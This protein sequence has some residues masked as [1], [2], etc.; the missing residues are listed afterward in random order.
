MQKSQTAPKATPQEFADDLL[1]GADAIAKFLFGPAGSRRKVYH[2][3]SY[4]R[5]PVFR[6]GSRLCAR[7]SVLLNW[8]GE[9]ENRAIYGANCKEP[10]NIESSDTLRAGARPRE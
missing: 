10:S 6:L 1:C 8:I 7:P 2:L 4:S 5:L 9:Q 3:A